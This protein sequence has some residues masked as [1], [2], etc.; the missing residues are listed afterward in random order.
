MIEEGILIDVLTVLVQRN[1]II[2]EEVEAVKKYPAKTR[3]FGWNDCVVI[4]IRKENDPDDFWEIVDPV[5]VEEYILGKKFVMMQW[6]ENFPPN[7]WKSLD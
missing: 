1:S 5:D 3:I 2:L 6:E 4:Q 7:A